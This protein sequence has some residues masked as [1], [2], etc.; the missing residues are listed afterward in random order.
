[1]VADRGGQQRYAAAELHKQR[2][3]ASIRGQ[4]MTLAEWLAHYQ[5]QPSYTIEVRQQGGVSRADIVDKTVW[6]MAGRSSLT[7]RTG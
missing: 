3:A 5:A 6:F 7:A 1:M 2:I 4:A